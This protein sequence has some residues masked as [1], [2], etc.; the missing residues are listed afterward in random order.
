MNDPSPPETRSEAKQAPVDWIK[1]ALE[2]LPMVV[3]LGCY[4]LYPAPREE[5][6]Y[7][8]IIGTTAAM[9]VTTVAHRLLYKKFNFM[10]VLTLILLI[11]FGGS[12][13]L[14][15]SKTYFLWKPTVLYG[16][17]AVILASGNLFKRPLLQLLLKQHVSLPK[18][19][20]YKLTW[21]WSAFCAFLGGVNLL[22]AYNFSEATWATFKVFGFMALTFLFILAQIPILIKGSEQYEKTNEQTDS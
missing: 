10:H 7:I 15:R 21:M 18:A 9:A 17:L 5:A 22:V 13:L 2:M 16:L 3:F 1:F 14:L 6:L 20:W 11:L 8:S 12:S 19:V 4:F